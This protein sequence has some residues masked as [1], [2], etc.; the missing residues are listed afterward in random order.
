MYFPLE[1]LLIIMVIHLKFRNMKA[2]IILV[3]TLVVCGNKQLLSQNVTLKAI[4]FN[5]LKTTPVPEIA[6]SLEDGDRNK[7]NKEEVSDTL[8]LPI[9]GIPANTTVSIGGNPGDANGNF[10]ITPLIRA[11]MQQAKTVASLNVT[12]HTTVNTTE[13]PCGIVKINKLASNRQ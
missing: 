8:I 10:N 12:L 1:N 4:P 5:K 2:I 3:F 7:F 9:S 11:T 6:V 13:K